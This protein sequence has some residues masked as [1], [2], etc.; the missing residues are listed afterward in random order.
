M[1]ED[2]IPE[3]AMG[4]S[5]NGGFWLRHQ[6]AIHRYTAAIPGSSMKALC[7]TTTITTTTSTITTYQDNNKVLVSG[8]EGEISTIN[9]ESLPVTLQLKPLNLPNQ[10]PSTTIVKLPQSIERKIL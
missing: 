4:L 7:T 10:L 6:F 3:K 8:I 1:L 5:I 2:Q 9:K